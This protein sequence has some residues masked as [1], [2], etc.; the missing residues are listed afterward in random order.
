MNI[1]Y[2]QLLIAQ[3]KRIFVFK[4]HGTVTKK[5][6]PVKPKGLSKPITGF[7]TRICNPV[8]AEAIDFY[9]VERMRNHLHGSFENP[10]RLSETP[11]SGL[12]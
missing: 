1:I 6:L 9:S 10:I 3:E 11:Q 4:F 5:V 2:Q 8:L 12:H 7:E